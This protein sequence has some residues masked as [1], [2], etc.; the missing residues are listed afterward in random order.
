MK[1]YACHRAGSWLINT[2]FRIRINAWVLGE[3]DQ[4]Q[5]NLQK[6]GGNT[7]GP[8][9]CWRRFVLGTRAVQKQG[10]GLICPCGWL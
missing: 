8:G 2:S 4:P 9:T 10:G 5:G 3:S 1:G 7:E 6:S